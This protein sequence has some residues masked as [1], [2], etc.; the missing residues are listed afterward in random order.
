MALSVLG[1]GNGFTAHKAI[2]DG[3]IDL[4][5]GSEVRRMIDRVKIEIGPDLDKKYPYFVADVT[6]HFKDGSSRHI[7]EEQSKG[8]PKKP[9]TPEEHMKKL[10]DLTTAFIG[11]EQAMR[12]WALVDEMKPDRPA[13]E[14]MALVLPGA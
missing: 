3:E 12:L 9:F 13:S 10:D 8:S 7:F 6:V 4:G 14:V 1:M 11:K 5:E 2:L